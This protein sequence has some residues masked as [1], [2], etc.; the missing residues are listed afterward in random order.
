MNP[1][2]NTVR[3]VGASD[4][5]GDDTGVANAQS[6]ACSFA[7]ATSCP[8]DLSRRLAPLT[9][10]VTCPEPRAVMISIA[11][12]SQEFAELRKHSEAVDNHNESLLE[13]G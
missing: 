2:M 12:A 7:E 9:C 1:G 8:D 10:P 4:V 11:R 3:G 13:A 6:N 5:S